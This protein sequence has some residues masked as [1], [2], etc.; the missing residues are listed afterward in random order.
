MLLKFYIERKIREFKT[1][2]TDLA[3]IVT[4]INIRLRL[5]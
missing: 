3:H 1:H 2:Q 4:R 5:L